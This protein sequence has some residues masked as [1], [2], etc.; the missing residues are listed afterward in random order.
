MRL[1]ERFPELADIDPNI[2]EM[3]LSAARGK[4]DSEQFGDMFVLAVQYLAAHS[5]SCLE[6][7]QRTNISHYLSAAPS[8]KNSI[9]KLAYER[10]KAQAEARH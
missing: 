2:T 1:E 8:L 3:E 4:V 7:S 10:L 6:G 5:L 9:Y